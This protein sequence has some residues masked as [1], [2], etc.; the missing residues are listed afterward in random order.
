M[1]SLL[2]IETEDLTR[3]F[4]TLTAVDDLTMS[5]RKG[6][7]V[8]VLGPNGAGKTT[9][10]RML[11]GGLAPTKGT[12]QINGFDVVTEGT[13]ARAQIGY[14]P[15]ENSAYCSDMSIRTFCRYM[16]R[17][18]G[19]SGMILTNEVQEKLSLV[20]LDQLD[21]RRIDTL[22]SGQKQR[23]GIAQAMLG[24]PEILIADEPTANLDPHG[25]K[26]IIALF[27]SLVHDDIPRAFF[28]STHIL[29][30]AEALADRII[31]ID[32]GKIVE[33]RTLDDIRQAHH[34]Y[35]F[36]VN[37][38]D[39]KTLNNALD[40]PWVVDTRFVS[41][42]LEIRTNEPDILMKNL[43][44]IIATNNLALYMFKPTTTQLESIFFELTNN[45]KEGG[46][47]Q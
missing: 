15:E 20:Q 3:K 2:A 32:Q 8:V 14:V 39:V 1:I 47:K 5:V 23:L 43:P 9:T 33:D 22:S 34:G 13:N 45:K 28:V 46:K 27:R 25:K 29:G 17:L 11:T 19:L 7:V 12:A 41:G 42:G 4:G 10:I 35:A 31:I 36:F 30:E 18:R 38:S 21:R 24:D 40:E 26:E 16:G 37:V 44:K 6:E